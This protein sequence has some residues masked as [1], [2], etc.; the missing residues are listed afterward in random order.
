MGERHHLR[1]SVHADGHHLHP[2]GR[3][4]GPVRRRLPRPRR[5]ALRLR[6]PQ[7]H[8]LGA[9]LRPPH[10]PAGAPRHWPRPRVHAAG[11]HGRRPRRARRRH[12]RR[13]HARGGAA[14][15]RRSA[16]HVRLQHR[17]RREVPAAVHLLAGA[18]VLRGGRGGGVHVHR[19]DGVLL[20]PGAGR[21][22][23]PLLGAVRDVLRAGKLRELGARDRGGDR[24]GAGRAGRVDPRRH[25]PGPP[26]QLLLAARHALHRQLRNLP[27][28]R[29]V[30]HVQEDCGLILYGY[31]SMDYL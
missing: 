7:R 12:A 9:P 25:Q 3:H 15:C 31:I 30:V 27:D 13:R 17:R 20:R 22:A 6:H 4:A 11:A 18:A 8:A 21:H 23:E 19:A 26:R 24:N 10:R 28:H 29:A 5:R 2:P 16:R 14:A 1:G